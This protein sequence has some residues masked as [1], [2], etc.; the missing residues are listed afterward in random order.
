MSTPAAGRRPPVGRCKHND[1]SV[2]QTSRTTRVARK[3][4]GEEEESDSSIPTSAASD[5]LGHALGER[6]LCCPALFECKPLLRQ[7]VS[8]TQHATMPR[9]R[10]QSRVRIKS[11]TKQQMLDKCGWTSGTTR[12]QW[13]HK[14]LDRRWQQQNALQGTAAAPDTQR[15]SHVLSMGETSLAA[16]DNHGQS[17]HAEKALNSFGHLACVA[18]I[19]RQAVRGEFS[20]IPARSE[21]RETI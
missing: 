12:V 18:T 4:H 7:A 20:G 13:A 10:A 5:L 16:V 6:C 14:S 15:A 21:Q 9:L 19:L 3:Q 1:P 8:D 11:A 2:H 17:H